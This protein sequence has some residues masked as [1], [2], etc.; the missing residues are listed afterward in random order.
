MSGKFVTSALSPLRSFHSF[1]SGFC[2]SAPLT[3]VLG[4]A[5]NIPSVHENSVLAWGDGS[6]G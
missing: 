1:L 4:K 2:I 5:L 3:T 6:A